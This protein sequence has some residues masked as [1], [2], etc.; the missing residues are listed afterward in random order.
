MSDILFEKTKSPGLLDVFEIQTLMQ[1][2]G[3]WMILKSPF[4]AEGSW[5]CGFTLL[6]TS[7][8]NSRSDYPGYGNTAQEAAVDA[9][10]CFERYYP[11]LP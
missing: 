5:V 10:K 6:G 9:L 4:G 11:E 3:Y 7:G 2:R 1:E 8:F